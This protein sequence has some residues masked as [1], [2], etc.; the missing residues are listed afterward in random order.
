MPG[1]RTQGVLLRGV[2]GLP[3][4]VPQELL[5][6]QA[7]LGPT[8]TLVWINMLALSQLGRPLKIDHLTEKMGLDKLEISK[9]LALLADQGWINDEGLEIQLTVPGH[10]ETAAVSEEPAEAEP[11]AFE[12]LVSY[13]SARVAMASP[14]EMRKLLYWME[15]KAL[16]H[17]VIA[18]AIEE[19]IVSAA[20][21][22]FAYLEGILR[23]WHAVGIR[24]YNDLLENSHLTKVLG[25]IAGR[26]E[27]SPAEQKWKE[28]FP[29]ELD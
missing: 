11:E 12:W 6:C 8:A 22:S 13:Y 15:A 26:R 23:N 18:V 27:L 28:V 21:P 3:I 24:T 17:E 29:D 7:Q 19:M 16:S 2:A 20:H 1:Q 25:P 14:E 5:H 4:Q 10:L 9:A